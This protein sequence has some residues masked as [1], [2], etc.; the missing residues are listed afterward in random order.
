M[1]PTPSSELIFEITQEEDGGYVAECLTENIVTQGDNWE[2]LRVNVK[3]AVQAHFF[4]GPRP[5]AI[6]LRLVRNEILLM[7]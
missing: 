1:Q 2:E 6:Q 7:Q 4:D 3:D 5:Q